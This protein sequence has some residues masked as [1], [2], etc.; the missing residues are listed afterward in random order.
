MRWIPSLR[1]DT[2]GLEHEE[3]SEVVSYVLVQ[4]LVLFLVLALLQFAF[5]LHTRNMVIAAASE[6][7]RRGALL[8]AGDAEAVERTEALLDGLVGARHYE[9]STSREALG[10]RSVLVVT[11]KADLPLLVNLG[12]SWLRASGSALVEEE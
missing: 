6:G 12:P 4:G 10:G 1:S 9:V 11:V 7:A 8:E 3:G 5:A 2:E